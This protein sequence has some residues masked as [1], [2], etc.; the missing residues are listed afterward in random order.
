MTAPPCLPRRSRPRS[1]M[2]L[3]APPAQSVGAYR[4]PTYPMASRW[5]GDSPA[6]APLYRPPGLRQE[7]SRRQ[8]E[9]LGEEA[10]RGVRARC[11]VDVEKLQRKTMRLKQQVV[12]SPAV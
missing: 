8:S 1:P 7:L 9:A 12:D 6:A 3:G 4:F 10:C 5:A 11:P 2:A